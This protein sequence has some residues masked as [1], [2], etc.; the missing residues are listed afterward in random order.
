ME[1]VPWIK[2]CPTRHMASPTDVEQ[3]RVQTDYNNKF[4][5]KH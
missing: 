5:S 2:I 3:T 1:K 4:N